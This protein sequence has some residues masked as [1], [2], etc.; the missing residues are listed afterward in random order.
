M[1]TD[2]LTRALLEHRNTPDPLTGLS[3]DMIIFGRE[4]KGFLP[5]EVHKYQPRKEWR[6]EA[7]DLR[8]QVHAKRHA[9]MAPVQLQEAGS[10]ALL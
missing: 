4:L 3:P 8:E 6:M 10:V 2:R 5:A 7:A 9:K 1:D